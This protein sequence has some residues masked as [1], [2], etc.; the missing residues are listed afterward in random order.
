MKKCNIAY[1]AC[2]AAVAGAGLGAAPAVA[3]HTIHVVH[4]GE[5]IQ[6]AV[7]AAA[8]GDTVLVTPGTYHES[9]R[10]T[11]PGLTLRGTGRGTVIAPGIPA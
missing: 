4:P 3:G 7:D 1:L 9:V 10:V 5:S 11:T 6:Q 8:P 2:A